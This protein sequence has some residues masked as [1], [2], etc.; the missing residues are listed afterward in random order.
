MKKELQWFN[1]RIGKI[2]LLE[3]TYGNWDKIT[4]RDLK[5][6]KHLYKINCITDEAFFSDPP[7]EKASL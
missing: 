5:H 1:N 6:A 2:V 3:Y 4:I 7:P